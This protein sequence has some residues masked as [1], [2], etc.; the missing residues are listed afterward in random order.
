MTGSPSRRR[1]LAALVAGTSTAAAGCS[2]PDFGSSG[3][4]DRDADELRETVAAL[5][6]EAATCRE[7]LAELRGLEL[8][9][10]SL[11]DK[12]LFDDEVHERMADVARERRESV[13]HLYVDHPDWDEPKT[14]AGTGWV[15]DDGLVATNAHVLDLAGNFFETQT[16][17]TFDGDRRDGELFALDERPRE[18]DA[19]L[20]EVST[21]GLDPLPIGS[22]E[23]LEIDDPLVR[24]GHPGQYGSWTMALAAYRGAGGHDT[25]FRDEG[26][27]GPGNSGSPILDEDGSVVGLHTGSGTFDEFGEDDAFEDSDFVFDE[28]IEKSSTVFER[29]PSRHVGNQ[30]QIEPVVELFEEWASG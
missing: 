6:A 16:V 30:H 10:M 4:D 15:Y 21:E 2:L 28:R 23:S 25:R 22:S 20:I 9:A 26:P 7:H 29:Y 24:I 18:L 1:L 8:E 13:V 14:P 27:S 11:D 12:P 3:T 5:E 19:A 17:E